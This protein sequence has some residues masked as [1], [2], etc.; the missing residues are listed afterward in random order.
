MTPRNF[1]LLLSYVE[2]DVTRQ[3]VV[4]EPLEPCERLAIALRRCVENA[5]GI[6]AAL[7]RILLRTIPL[8]PKNVDFIIKAACILHNF[9]TVENTQTQAY[10]DSED[11]FGNIVAGRWR[12]NLH[13]VQGNDAMQHFFPLESTHSRNFASDAAEV[14]NL[15]ASYF[16][17]AA[18]EVP[19][20]WAQ[21]GVSQ[22]KAMGSL[23]TQLLQ[24]LHR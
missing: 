4:R 5:F 3:Y 13:G 15:F 7:W 19:W 20:Q 12:Q 10:M 14:R 22:E 17:S 18:G 8:R 24:P 2:T 11:R 16:C 1:D 6:T 21:L 23:Q 9:L